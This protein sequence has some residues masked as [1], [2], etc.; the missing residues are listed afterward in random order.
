MFPDLEGKEENW[1]KRPE[2]SLYQLHLDSLTQDAPKLL[3]L[4]QI[5]QQL[6]TDIYGRPEKPV[7]FTSSP[8]MR[9]PFF[10][11]TIQDLK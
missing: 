6:G 10:T 5:I 11:G 7:I 1:L 2:D 4:E 8:V 3:A 9:L